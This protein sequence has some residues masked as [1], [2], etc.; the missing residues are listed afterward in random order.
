MPTNAADPAALLDG[1]NLQ[2]PAVVIDLFQKAAHANLECPHRHGA[3]DR[4][5]KRGRLLMTGDLHDNGL[6]LMRILKLAR[7]EDSPDNHVIIH[8]VI[9][10]GHFV[11]GRDFSV[12]MLA[13][14]AAL[15][16]AFPNQVHLMQA[17]HELA[18]LAGDG[19]LKDGISVCEAFDAGIEF[20]Y[21]ERSEAVREAMRRFIRSLLLAVR[22]ENGVFCSHSLPAVRKLDTFD[23]TLLDRVPTEDDLKHGGAAYDMVWGRRHTQELADKLGEKWNARLFVM[24]HQPVEMGYDIQG[25]SMLVLASDHDHGMAL[26]IDLSKKYDMDGLIGEMVP[27]ASVVL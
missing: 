25:T 9:H 1:V 10:G 8:E 18:Q 16:L 12:R 11:N 17:N 27:L 3:A 2:A 7:L 14:V 23:T 21:G 4:M 22:C 13:K 15:K 6:N 19:I 20:I 24:G 26:P 5:P